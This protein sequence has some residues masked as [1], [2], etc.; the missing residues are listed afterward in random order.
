M[1]DLA[2]KFCL[3]GKICIGMQGIVVSTELGK[4]INQVLSDDDVILGRLPRLERNRLR[5]SDL[6][7]SGI[8]RSW[9]SVQPIPQ[10]GKHIRRYH[11]ARRLRSRLEHAPDVSLPA[12]IRGGGS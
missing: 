9:P 1:R 11:M 2:D 10:Q 4:R 5:I 12:G 8:G 7:S 6:L 3:A